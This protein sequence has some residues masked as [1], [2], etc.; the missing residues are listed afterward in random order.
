MENNRTQSLLQNLTIQ[1]QPSQ[2]YP[3]P[4]SHPNNKYKKEGKDYLARTV[5]TFEKIKYKNEV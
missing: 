4:P 1:N 3:P 2:P 5:P